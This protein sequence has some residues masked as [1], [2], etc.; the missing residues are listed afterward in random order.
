M[1]INKS[2]VWGEIHTARWLRRNGYK[3]ITSN[4]RTRMGE[5]DIIASKGKY[6][7]FIEVKAR[8]EN[9]VARPMEAVDS[10][11][12][13]KL[14]ATSKL[15]LEKHPMKLQPRFDV[16]EVWLGEKFEVLKINYIENAYDG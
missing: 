12:Q 11:K 4:Y 10:A 9:A 5:V 1:E 7:C 6:L 13:E 8:G 15:F 3:I 16:C 2:G 14:I